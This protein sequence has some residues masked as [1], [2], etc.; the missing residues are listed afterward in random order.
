VQLKGLAGIHTVVWQL[1]KESAS[2]GI[3]E[4]V[5][6]KV[7]CEGTEVLAAGHVRLERVRLRTETFSGEISKTMTRDISRSGRAIAVL[8]YD[9]AAE[10]FI[11]AEQFRLGAY[12]NGVVNPWL[13]ECVAGMIDEGETAEAAARREVEEETG[14]K[15][16]RF[17]MIGRYLTSPGLSDELITI[18]VAA[19][20]ASRAEGVHGKPSEGE[21]IRTRVV[22]V[23]EALAAADRGE[24]LN[25]VAQL[26]FLW[27]ARHGESLRNRWLTSPVAA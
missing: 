13:L 11:L 20:D 23:Q 24:V 17:E 26:A 27:F 22:P 14:S 15:A 8:L 7:V 16:S 1:A 3:Q 5:P 18:Y 19:A 25:I 9:P 12:L 2:L 10:K 6:N 21:D 4:H